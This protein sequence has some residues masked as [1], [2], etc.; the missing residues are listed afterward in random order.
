MY[1][2]T[3]HVAMSVIPI[4]KKIVIIVDDKKVTRHHGNMIM[5]F[6]IFR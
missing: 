4:K 6:Y 1:G 3:V 5:N 2:I